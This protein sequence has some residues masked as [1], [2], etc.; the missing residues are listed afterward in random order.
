VPLSSLVRASLGAGYSSHIVLI[1]FI[2]AYLVWSERATIFSS[3]AYCI[4]PGALTGSV[5]LI[6]ALLAYSWAPRVAPASV[7][8]LTV[9]SAL[10]LV[11]AG[12]I[13]VFGANALKRSTFP[14]LLL[15]L[16]LPI[17]GVLIDRIIYLLQSGSAHLSASI[18]S[19]LGVPVLKNG[20]FLT[21]P[22]VTIEVASECSGIN[23]SVALLILML[24]FA[25]ETLKTN[26]RRIILV[27]LII[28]LSIL[29]NAI[30]IVTLTLLATK[31]DPGF[32]TGRLHHEGGF[33]F[34]LIT[35][36]LVY[37]IWRVLQASELRVR[38]TVNS[39][40]A[41]ISLS[42]SSRP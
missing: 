11:V 25:H 30:R 13:L 9:L 42:P 7:P 16:M 20:F 35:L 24:L 34:F 18:F 4:L 37:P 12:Y 41:A 1:P 5:G 17:P 28:P 14:I 33:V 29:K 19:L 38:K 3:P 26:S 31:V 15:G 6:L 2:A 39:Q 32:L 27:L 10:L 36:V 40:V 8:F 22:G 23:S 21:V